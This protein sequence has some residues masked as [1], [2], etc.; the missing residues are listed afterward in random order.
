MLRE[1]YRTFISPTYKR[2]YAVEVETW[3]E[4]SERAI[5]TLADSPETQQ[6]LISNL[7]RAQGVRVAGKMAI[8]SLLMDAEAGSLFVVQTLSQADLERMTGI[9]PE[10]EMG[11]SFLHELERKTGV[12][13]LPPSRDF[14]Q[15]D[16]AALIAHEFTHV[17]FEAR[18]LARG[19]FKVGE[20]AIPAH[21]ADEVLAY[22]TTAKIFEAE[23]GEGFK[24]LQN[25]VSERITQQYELTGTTT[26]SEIAVGGDAANDTADNFRLAYPT[27]YV[28]ALAG[29]VK[30]ELVP[31]AELV[32][33]LPEHITDHRY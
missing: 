15:V 20:Q 12:V 4:A 33:L 2:R 5:A 18:R 29:L 32:G 24:A 8:K 19:R 1:M 22:A 28:L 30:Q 7:N 16:R 26:P 6:R 17:D 11:A 13:C 23:V 27:A 10:R 31:T 3:Q 25:E 14:N 21:V 9:P